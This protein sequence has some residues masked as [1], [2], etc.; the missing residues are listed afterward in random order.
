MPTTPYVDPQSIHNPTPGGV[1]PASWGDAV[2]DGLEFLVRAPGAIAQRTAT[3]SISNGSWTSVPLGATD[4]R[5]TDDY[6]DTSVNTTRV[7]I[8]TGLGGW[9]DVIGACEWAAA[10]VGSRACRLIVNGSTSYT[11]QRTNSDADLIVCNQ[12]GTRMLL[13]AATD[14]VEFQVFQNKGSAVTLN[15][16]QL[17]VTLRALA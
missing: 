1:P 15:S 5:D 11:L 17:T 10:T 7:T 14:Y 6:H 12:S 9:Y 13:L 16:A 2:R 4:I 3:L 8:P